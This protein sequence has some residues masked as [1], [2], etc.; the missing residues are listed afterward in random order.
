[1]PNEIMVIIKFR[2][3]GVHRWLECNFDDVSYLGFFHRHMFHVTC[4]K[5]VYNA[6]R[7]IEIIRFRREVEAFAKDEYSRSEK[8]CEMMAQE[9]LETFNFNTVE[10]LEDGENGA[11]VRRTD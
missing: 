9:L 1:M 2:F 8:S 5:R 6:N 7:E 4:W 11:V 10:V 3:E